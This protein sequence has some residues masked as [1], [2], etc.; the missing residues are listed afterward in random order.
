[1][2]SKKFLAGSLAV[3]MLSTV[4]MFASPTQ[5]SM[6]AA[7]SVQQNARIASSVHL[8]KDADSNIISF[9]VN[10]VQPSDAEILIR[11]DSAPLSTEFTIIKG[12]NEEGGTSYFM[13]PT[14][15]ATSLVVETISKDLVNAGSTSIQI[16]KQTNGKY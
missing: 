16:S 12:V 14:T 7:A 8:T 10:G 1:M 5:E 2:S 6:R 15:V 9:H 13:L 4:T 11:K 3:A